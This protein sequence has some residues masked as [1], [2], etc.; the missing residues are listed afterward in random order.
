MLHFRWTLSRTVMAVRTWA[1]VTPTCQQQKD[2]NVRGG[3]CLKKIH[4]ERCQ[5]K[6]EK[7]KWPNTAVML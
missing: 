1:A 5:K 3:L 7:E 6:E 2:E 4:F